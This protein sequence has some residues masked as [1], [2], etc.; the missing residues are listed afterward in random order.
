MKEAN[1]RGDSIRTDGSR[2]ESN[3]ARVSGREGL[4]LM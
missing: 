4:V 2:E 1:T 3:G